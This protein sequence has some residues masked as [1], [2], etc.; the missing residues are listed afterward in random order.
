M[1]LFVA[2]L[3]SLISLTLSTAHAEAI[4]VVT[5]HSPPIAF[6]KDGEVV[7]IAT[8]LVREGLRRMGHETVIT[9]TPWKRA[10]FMTRYGQADAIFY[11]LK[12]DQREDWFHYPDE[13]LVMETTV[14]LKRKGGG[15]RW[16]P[17]QREYTKIRLGTG[18][19][20]Y[21]GPKLEHF[22][23]T[24]A[25]EAVEEATSIDLNFAKLLQGR[26][27]V[28]LADLHLVNYSINRNAARDEVEIV[29]DNEGSPVIFDSEESYLAFSKRTM[30]KAMADQFSETLASMKADGTYDRIV[31]RYR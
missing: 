21:Y 24:T 27:D 29:T 1:K 25:F 15:F 13:H 8:D 23:K 10:I 11:A 9:I 17:E 20:Y 19:G 6:E 26:V 4:R 28:F 16:D 5:L 3:I 22:L 18:R 14:L 7:G 12:N 2:A 31:S 30:T